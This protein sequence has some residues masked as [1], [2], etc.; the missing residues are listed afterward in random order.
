MKV[1]ITGEKIQWKSD[2]FVKDEAINKGERTQFMDLAKTAYGVDHWDKLAHETA[3]MTVSMAEPGFRLLFEKFFEDGEESTM[4]KV[5]KF[6]KWLH[7]IYEAVYDEND[8]SWMARAVHA[9]HQKL[10][11]WKDNPANITDKHIMFWSATPHDDKYCKD[12]ESAVK[13]AL[14]ERFFG[15]ARKDAISVPWSVFKQPVTATLG[16]VVDM[17]AF[18][19]IM[20]ER[21]ELDIHVSTY[22][23]GHRWF[24]AY[25]PL[26]VGL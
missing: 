23:L 21:E 16:E 5:M 24:G 14:W 3:T 13:C 18:I 4:G 2:D 22:Q 11:E 10:D 8:L 6:L 15:A 9:A 19:E 26:A 7:W 25:R 12:E 1:E 20:N 17:D